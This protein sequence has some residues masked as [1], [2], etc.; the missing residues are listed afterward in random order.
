MINSILH[1]QPVALDRERHRD[2]RHDRELR[3]LSPVAGLNAYFISVSEFADVALEYPIL[4]VP[5]QGPDGKRTMAPVAAFGLAQGENLFVDGNRWDAAYVPAHLRIYPFAVSRDSAT[6]HTIVVDES[7][8][9]LSRERGDALFGP[10]GELS[11]Y[12]AEVQEFLQALEVDIDHTQRLCDHLLELDIMQTMRFDATLPDG[13]PLVVDGF[14]AVDEKKF[15]ELP[16]AAVL[17]LY[18]SGMLG[19]LH[20]HQLSLRQMRRLVERRVRRARAA[21]PAAA[22]D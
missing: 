18:R 14:L 5:S 20:A 12:L 19:L 7:S 6:T 10:G 16:D 3:D 22:N 2:L 21:A 4:F 9:A 15:A 8:Q 13:S 1:K 17:E 11:P